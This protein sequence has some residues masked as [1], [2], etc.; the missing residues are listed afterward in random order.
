M[1]PQY[2]PLARPGVGDGERRPRRVRRNFVDDGAHR[3]R[4]TQSGAARTAQRHREGFVR[5][6]GGVLARPHLDRP[7]R[8]P[9]S[10]SQR[11]RLR[12]VVRA[13]R[14]R[15]ARRLVAHRHGRP[16]GPTQR[17]LE[18]KHFPLDPSGIGDRNGWG[19]TVADI[20]RA[21]AILVVTAVAAI[22]RA[23][24]ILAVAVVSSVAVDSVVAAA[25]VVSA[26][27]VAGRPPVVVR[28]GRAAADPDGHRTP[29]V[30]RAK[31]LS[32]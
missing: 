4:I 12:I 30:Y 26:A 1:E 15:P 21:S 5:L 23:S 25:P 32:L 22:V 13:L 18:A 27:G 10:K 20:A 14:G 3:A 8:G 17:D 2:L 29:T 24:A 28:R 7:P 31:G 6:V 9:E 19:N 16:A 11:A